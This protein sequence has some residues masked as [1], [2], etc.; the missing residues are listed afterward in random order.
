MT[1]VLSIPYPTPSLNAFANPSGRRWKYAQIRKH[2]H[3]YAQDALL[4]ARAEARRPL[5][6]PRPPAEPVR[7]EVIRFAPEHQ[8]LDR[9]N[10]YGGL[11]P[12]LDALRS[13]EVLADD[14][15]KAIDLVARQE[16]S[17]HRV[18]ARWTEIRLRL[19]P[20]ALHEVHA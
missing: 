11:K 16:V 14:T 7:V 18:P 12:L 3:R 17:P 5:A 19:D 15:T 10:L 4:E 9:D 20:P 1:L 6:W 13:F 8:W 2:W